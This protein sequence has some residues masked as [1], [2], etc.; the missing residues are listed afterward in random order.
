MKYYNEVRILGEGYAGLARRRADRA[1]S[2]PPSS[3]RA[4]PPIYPDLIYDRHRGRGQPAPVPFSLAADRAN[5]ADLLKMRCRV[6]PQ[7]CA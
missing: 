2:W 7:I 6:I 4:A 3:R 5:N 1:H